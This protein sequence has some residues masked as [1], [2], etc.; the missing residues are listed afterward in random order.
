MGGLLDEVVE[1]IVN[2]VFEVGKKA[3]DRVSRRRSIEL[4]R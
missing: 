1:D 4:T 3:I 2:N